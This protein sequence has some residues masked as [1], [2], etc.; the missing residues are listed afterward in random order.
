VTGA[1]DALLRAW[2]TAT[3]LGSPLAPLVVAA[4]LRAGKEHPDRWRERLGYP[5]VPVEEDLPT[6][7][8]HAASVGETVAVMPLVA[9]IAATG[10]RVVFTT[11]TVTSAEIAAGRL[12]DGAVHQFVPLDTAPGVDRFLATWTPGLA[13]LVESE[14]WPVAIARL[15]DR[16]IPLVISN[17][18]MSDRSF[19]GWSRFPRAAAALFGRVGLCLAQSPADADRFRALGAPRVTDVGNIKFDAPVPEAPPAAAAAIASAFGDRPVFV[20]ASTHP[21]EEAIVLDAF[22]DLRARLPGLLLV[23]V[24]RHPDRGASVAATVADRGL[25]VV[26]RYA[27]DLP[28]PGTDVYVADTIGELGTFYRLAGAAFVGGSFVPVGGHNPVEPARLGAPVVSGPQVASF[29]DAYAALEAEG[30]VTMVADAAALAADVAALLTDP[31][32]RARRTEAAGR[33]IARHAGALERTFRLVEPLIDALAV[34]ARLDMSG[35]RS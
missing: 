22:A 3:R 15:S 20:A 12:P 19:R 6:V 11:V 9:R 14:I 2:V 29:R 25:A 7:W 35:G 18:R 33:V 32:A 26:R 16:A 8:V 34:E 5:G 4:R 13:I 10:V 23:V 24:P 27:G 1:G 17:A 30:G 21:G 28:T 31:V